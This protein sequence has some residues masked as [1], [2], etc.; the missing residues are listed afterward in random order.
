MKICVL[1]TTMHQSDFSRYDDMNLQSDAV[2]ANQCDIN[3]ITETVVGGHKVKMVSTDGR[4]ASLNRNIA[5]EH[6]YEDEYLLFADDDLVFA[7]GYEDVIAT[8]FEAHPEAE[9]IKFNL[10]FTG[11]GSRTSMKPIEKWERA[12]RKNMSSSGVWGI[13]IKRNVLKRVNLFFDE[14]FG[15]GTANYCGEDTIFVQSLL[16]RKVRMYR[17]DKYIAAVDQKNSS[18]YEGR[19]K[20]YYETVGMVFQR[21]YPGAAWLLAVRSSYKHSKKDGS[22]LSFAEMLKCYTDGINRVRR[23]DY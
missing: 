3:E 22:G 1:V 4:G 6:S 14:S 5:M 8:E 21:I 17:S 12:T 20:R 23:G 9:A 18:W 11:D 16:K 10:R 15:P 2:I 19:T 7:D 13:V